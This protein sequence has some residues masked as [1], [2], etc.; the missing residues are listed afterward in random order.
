MCCRQVVAELAAPDCSRNFSSFNATLL[1]Q[2]YVDFAKAVGNHTV[3]MQLSTLPSWLFSDGYPISKCNDD[4]WQPCEAYGTTGGTLRD[5]V[6]PTP[7]R[8][9]GRISPIFPSFFP[10]FCAFSPSRRGGS[11][12]PQAGTQGQE[13]AGARGK[14]GELRPSFDTTGAGGRIT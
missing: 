14:S 1:S 11:N 6:I 2:I 8:V 4:P 10:V 7:S 3:A 9:L 5:Q 12:E 13:T